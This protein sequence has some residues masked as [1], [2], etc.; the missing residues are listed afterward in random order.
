[1]K[2]LMIYVFGLLL[3]TVALVVTAIETEDGIEDED[4]TTSGLNTAITTLSNAS[5]ALFVEDA[6]NGAPGTVDAANYKL[7]GAT[8]GPTVDWNNEEL[9]N[10]GV[11]ILD[12]AD[13]LLTDGDGNDVMKWGGGPAVGASYRYLYN[14]SSN[15]VVDF[16]ANVLQGQ[17]DG[18][19]SDTAGTAGN[20]IMR[21]IDVTNLAA[22]W[23]G[24]NRYNSAGVLQAS[25][26]NVQSAIDATDPGDV[27]RIGPGTYT[28]SGA[29]INTNAT[30]AGAGVDSTILNVDSGYGLYIGN[31]TAATGTIA[32]LTV[33]ST[34]AQTLIK[35]MPDNSRLNLQHAKVS[36][37]GGIAIEWGITDLVSGTNALYMNHCEIVGTLGDTDKCNVYPIYTLYDPTDI[38]AETTI[39]VSDDDSLAYSLSN[40]VWNAAQYPS[41]YLT[42]GTRAHAANENGGGFKTTNWNEIVAVTGTFSGPV[43][44]TVPT[45]GLGV[46]TNLNGTN[47]FLWDVNGTNYY[48][49]AETNAIPGGPFYSLDVDGDADVDGILTTA[50]TNTIGRSIKA[51]SEGTNTIWLYKFTL[52]ATLVDVEYQADGASAVFDVVLKHQTNGFGNYT[53]ANL[54]LTANAT[55]AQDA[56]WTQSTVTNGYWIGINNTNYTTAMTNYTFFIH[57]V[58]Q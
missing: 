52:D 28:V 20:D 14:K 32:N 39:V 41:A 48:I 21:W 31:G 5:T 17:G 37:S 19:E 26:T 36:T 33:S 58:D 25:Y 38:S 35:L 8:G 51:S 45:G 16:S 6:T 46:Y 43:T 56:T 54:G 29:I 3:M 34:N 13:G 57:Y 15:V 30:V 24:A 49:V 2:K 47:V 12:W 4:V 42:D 10:L 55:W 44:T 22:Q 23:L 40:V 53:T 7:T 50:N 1:M 27:V 18:W 9:R 11:V